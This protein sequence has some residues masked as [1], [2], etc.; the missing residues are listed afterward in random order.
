M[1]RSWLKIYRPGC[2]L[3]L[4]VFGVALLYAASATG[5]RLR[6]AI[7]TIELDS[8]GRY[9]AEV[10]L[11]LEALLAGIGPEHQ[12]TREA[13][14][15]AEYDAMRQLPAAQLR[16]RFA[17]F[18]QRYLMGISLSIDGQR[19]EP[20]LVSLEIPP[21]GDVAVERL[22]QITLAGTLPADG[23]QLIWSYAP[24]FGEHVLRVATVEQGVIRAEWLKPGQSSEAFPLDAAV[25]ASPT[26]AQVF[27]DYTRLGFTHILPKGL[28]HMLFVLGIF[29]LSLKWRPLLY[30]VTAFTLAHSI[31]LA[32]S[33]YGL[34]SLPAS[35][36]EP[37]IALSIVYIAVE[38]I[39]IAGLKPW[40]IWVVFGFGLLHGLGF[41]GVLTELGLP[42]NEFLT[43]LIGFNLGVELGQLVVI[44]LAF[45]A[46]GVWFHKQP[47]YRRV[48]V[49]PGSVVIALVGSY[50]LVERIA[51]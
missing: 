3:L 5:H 35:V 50:W 27:I 40:R 13:P 4:M 51:G 45:L 33:L 19:L 10:K 6:P 24:E 12:D 23:R 25:V 7:I 14:Q 38:N 49:V 48:V 36:V 41:A 28:D 30:Q 15:A 18:K 43:A 31:T 21:V 32:M 9:A 34:I 44:A 20:E 17:A 29:L 22:T 46:I 47:W 2:Y 8:E 37:L 42:R 39:L 16:Q 11:N 1:K 26:T